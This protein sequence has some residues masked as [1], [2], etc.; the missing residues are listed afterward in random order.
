MRNKF[1]TIYENEIL[2]LSDETPYSHKITVSDYAGN[3]SIEEIPKDEEAPLEISGFTELRKESGKAELN[4]TKPADIDISKVNIKY[5]NIDDETQEEADERE[6]TQ[7]KTLKIEEASTLAKEAIETYRKELNV[8][9]Q[10]LPGFVIAEGGTGN[11]S[12]AAACIVNGAAIGSRRICRK[13]RF[14]RG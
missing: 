11:G 8:I 9:D 12:S 4:W 2:G 1:D 10:D 7:A 13:N 6:L 3:T 14:V 5:Q